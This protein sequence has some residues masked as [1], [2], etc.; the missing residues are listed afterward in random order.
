MS[1]NDHD[2]STRVTG[3]EERRKRGYCRLSV[4]N[5]TDR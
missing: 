5:L 3:G 2:R 4:E 1:P